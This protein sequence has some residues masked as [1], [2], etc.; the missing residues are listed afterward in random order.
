LEK[1]FLMQARLGESTGHSVSLRKDQLEILASVVKPG[2]QMNPFKGEVIQ[3]RN[4]CIWHMMLLTAPR[5]GELVLLEL[6]D[7]EFR[8]LPTVTIREPSLNSVNKRRDGASLKTEA[9]VLPLTN[10]V[11]RLLETYIEEWRHH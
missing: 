1:L 4:C 2:S 10:H 8:A 6:R 5:R 3:A 11:A 9:R 7:I